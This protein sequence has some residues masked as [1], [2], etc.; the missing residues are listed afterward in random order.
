M[1]MGA[2]FVVWRVIGGEH[3]E[4]FGEN[5]ELHLGNLCVKNGK[6]RFT[7]WPLKAEQN[8]VQSL[9]GIG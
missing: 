6:Y 5:G 4:R 3:L 2:R 8:M 7:L 9:L 1:W